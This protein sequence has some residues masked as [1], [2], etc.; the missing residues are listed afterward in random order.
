M[1]PSALCRC[2]LVYRQVTGAADVRY[3]HSLWIRLWTAE[4]QAPPRGPVGPWPGLG[5]GA[6]GPGAPR[7]SGGVS[8]DYS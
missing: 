7:E 2:Q 4:R 8:D 5:G 1:E 3:K 6:G